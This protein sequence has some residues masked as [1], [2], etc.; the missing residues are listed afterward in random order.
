MIFMPKPYP[1]EPR[2]RA[3]RLVIEHRSKYVTECGNLVGRGKAENRAA[4]SPRNCVRRAE[5]NAAQAGGASSEEATDPRRLLLAVWLGAGAGP[6][7]SCFPAP[8]SGDR[9]TAMLRSIARFIT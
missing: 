8:G 5:V 6:A 7:W 2:E 4:E 3:A 1:T 9:P